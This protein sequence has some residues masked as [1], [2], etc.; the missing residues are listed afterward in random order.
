MLMAGGPARDPLRWAI[1]VILLLLLSP[2]I[3]AS[4]A[5]GGVGIAVVALA[6]L[7][8]RLAAMAPRSID[9]EAF[10]GPPRRGPSLR[11]EAVGG[12]LRSGPRRPAPSTAARPR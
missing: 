4:L 12:R 11:Q 2:A 7:V 10:R 6:R 1:Q 3:L 8:G 9:L 5:V